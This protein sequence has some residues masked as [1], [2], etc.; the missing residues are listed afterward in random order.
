MEELVASLLPHALILIQVKVPSVV[1]RP[2]KARRPLPTRTTRRST[3]IYSCSACWRPKIFCSTGSARFSGS[4]H[5]PR[6]IP[7]SVFP[8]L[9]VISSM[10][11][12]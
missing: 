9:Q 12:S 10:G 8:R 1:Q 2:G 4:K 11:H 6:S 7:I 5:I 3:Y